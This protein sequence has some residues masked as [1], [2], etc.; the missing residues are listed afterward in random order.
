[1]QKAL[2]QLL[3]LLVRSS[4][5]RQRFQLCERG[6][7]FYVSLVGRRRRSRYVGWG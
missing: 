7:R 2:K 5:A 6:L 4:L 1:L 3:G